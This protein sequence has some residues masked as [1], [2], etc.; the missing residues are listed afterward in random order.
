M[1]SSL[2]SLQYLGI[3]EQNNLNISALQKERPPRNTATIRPESFK[4]LDIS[5]V[6]NERQ[7]RNTATIRPEA[8][9]DLDPESILREATVA[10]GAFG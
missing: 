7:P 10:V 5:A 1:F 3:P 4:Y 9:K 6:Q 8:L 2:I